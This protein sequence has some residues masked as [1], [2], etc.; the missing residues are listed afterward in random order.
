MDSESETENTMNRTLSQYAY[1]IAESAVRKGLDETGWA[2]RNFTAAAFPSLPQEE[3]IVALC[4]GVKWYLDTLDGESDYVLGAGVG[5]IIEGIRVLL[6]GD[7]GRLDAGTV[8]A[9]LCDAALAAGWDLDAGK[10]VGVSD[11]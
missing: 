11:D 1:V 5:Q 3:A 6:N 8:D 9:W 10:F 2:K 7:I 4:D